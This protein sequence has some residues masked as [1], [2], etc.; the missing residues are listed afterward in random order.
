MK[1]IDRSITSFIVVDTEGR[2][3]LKE[4]AIL[5]HQGKLL[6]QAWVAEHPDNAERAS[7]TQSLQIILDR[8]LSIARHHTIVC[9]HA[10][11]DRQVIYRACRMANIPVPV[12]Q[13]ICTWELAQVTFPDLTRYSL[14]YLSKKLA[15]KVDQKPFNPRQAHTSKYD[16]EFTY[17]L[18]QK[19]LD[20]QP[21]QSP[22]SNPTM[23]PLL[24]SKPNPFA[25]SRVDTPFQNHPDQKQIYQ[26]EFE[27][28]K[29][30]IAEIH[31]DSNHQSR[32]AVVIGEPGSGKTHLMMRLAQ[33]LLKV[34][35]LLFIRHP[36]NPDAILYHIYS[37][38]LESVIQTV[39][40]T[41]YTQLEHLISHSFTKLIR[42]SRHLTLTSTDQTILTAVKD[43]P[44]NLYKLTA[45]GTDKKR[46]LW[47]H[48]DK[49][50]QEWWVDTY[51][52]SGSATQI[53]KGIVKFC[54]YSDKRRKSIVQRWLAAN[55]LSQDDLELVGL[56]DWQENLGTEE[57]SLEAIAV[58]S[59][60]SL[61][62]EPLLIVFDQLE[63]LGLPH[64]EKL[65][66]N[67]GEA[68]KE[69]FTHVPN[70]L[71]ILNLF[72]DRWQ[73]FQQLLSPAVVDRVSQVQIQLQPPNEQ[74]LRQIL[75]F[76]A[77]S[78]DAKITDLFKPEDLIVILKQQSIRGM[79]NWAANYFRYRVHGVPLPE[80]TKPPSLPP[81]EPIVKSVEQRLDRLESAMTELQKQL[82]EMSKRITGAIPVNPEPI[83]P[84]G[85][86]N[87]Y[88]RSKR[89]SLKQDYQNPQIITD[90]DDLGK[91]TTIAEAFQSLYPL[92]IDYLRLGRRVLPE[93]LVLVE[94]QKV[95]IGFLQIDGTSFTNRIKNW[96]ETVITD[97]S[98]QYQLWRDS[99]LPE[100]TGKVGRG[101]IE[102]LNHTPHGQFMILGEEERIDF[103][104]IYGL[105]IDLQNRDLDLTL[106]DTI[107]MIMIDLSESWLIQ[108]M[109][110]L[111]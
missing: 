74:T 81:V 12:L 17:Q 100:I 64:N 19:I 11:H 33:E 108:L 77:Q 50:L 10:Q 67:F 1:S 6:Y 82:Q 85:Y 95:A 40:G 84:E 104:L 72:P 90:S 73:Q 28:L 102:K 7:Q 44:L 107:Q 66:L 57:F 30:A 65:L 34:N 80:T 56:N 101:E 70:S 20:T 24:K 86:L 96:N 62:D 16:T 76:R 23:D 5:D 47:N 35:R 8:F 87:Q 71:I 42:T 39:P 25:S 61:L 105:I 22:S 37:R 45:E 36:N 26:Q 78:I 54:S 97:R 32:G 111:I 89:Q 14:E 48:I 55:S 21:C 52:F 93:H 63:S 29:I 18:Y 92:E 49:R 58:L 106:E 98:I 69:I 46:S 2:D 9:H 41:D 83:P 68:V 109:Q 75:E 53:L 60:L 15:L 59:K 110:S 51:G 13:F 103:E 27:Q 4:I 3:V 79:I 94:K 99:R 88:L 38:I 91:L 43:S 31:Q